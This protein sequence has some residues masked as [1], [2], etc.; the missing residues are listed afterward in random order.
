MCQN[1]SFQL[2][3][4]GKF[5]PQ[6]KTL[7][8]LYSNIFILKPKKLALLVLPKAAKH[9]TNSWFSSFHLSQVHLLI[10][11]CWTYVTPCFHRTLGLLAICED[12]YTILYQQY[13]ISVF[14]LFYFQ[15]CN[16]ACLAIIHNKILLKSGF[17]KRYERKTI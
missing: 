5:T 16:V 8:H 14:F 6:K 9:T 12:S 13:H 11:F 2:V 17:K 4:V 7:M 10:V 1:H 15:F 3:N